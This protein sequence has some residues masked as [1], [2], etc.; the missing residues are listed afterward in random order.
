[1]NIEDCWYKSNCNQESCTQSCIRFN[2]MQSLYK[3]SLIP[4]SMWNTGIKVLDCKETD[5]SAFHY[6]NDINMF[7]FVSNG[8]NLYICSDICGNGKTSWSIKLMHRYFNLIWHKSGFNCHGL[9]IN[10]PK[11]LYTCKRAISQKVEGF[12]ELCENIAKCDLVIWDDL[13]CA[14]FTGYEHQII[15]QYIDDRINAGK[16]NIYTGNCDKEECKK[17][18]GERLTSRVFG[19][20]TVI[21]FFEEDKRGLNNGRITNT[22]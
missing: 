2:C 8:E 14:E 17:L 20:G 11:F 6:L 22:K 1:M 10:V 21:K 19:C 16:S 7:D 13:P 5:S 4:E 12:D 3:K 18:L 9:F 15:L